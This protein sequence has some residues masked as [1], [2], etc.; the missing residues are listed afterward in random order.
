MNR[1]DFVAV[2]GG[3]LA[4]SSSAAYA[5]ETKPR[6]LEMRLIK[7]RNTL[8]NMSQR[9]NDYLSK[10]YIPALNRAGVTP[11]GVFVSVIAQDSPFV[12]LLSQYADLAAYDAAMQKL[13]ADAEHSKS[14]AGFASGSAPFARMEVTLLRG[15]ATVPAIEVPP[16]PPEKKSHVFE[17]RRY[18]SNTPFSLQ[19]KIK[20]FDEGEIELFRKVNIRPVFFGETIAG[21][22]MPNLTYMVAFEDLAARE[23]AWSTFGSHPEWIKMRSQPGL[24][25]AEIVSNISNYIVR[26][27]AYSAIR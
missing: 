3:T 10:S 23:K 25:D 21:G 20:M 15:F 1:R 22:N 14:L 18:E 27:A 11:V 24:S 26:P 4:M 17:V 16:S 19:K 12:L 6:I 2:S 7:L 5:A 9:T 8:D 13:S